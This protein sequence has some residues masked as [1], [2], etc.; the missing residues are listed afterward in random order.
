MKLH[1]KITIR[2]FRMACF[3][4]ILTLLFAEVSDVLVRKSLAEPWNMSVK[5]GGFYNEPKNSFDVMYFGSSHMYCSIDPQ[6]VEEQTGLHSYVLA[7]QEQP[8]WI[9][10]YYMKEALK[11]QSPKAIV[12]EVNM[13]MEDKK[14]PKE[15]T[16]YSAMDPIPLS[17]NKIDM[18]LASAPKGERR[19]YIFNIMKYHGR[20]EELNLEDYKRTYQKKCDPYQ[21]YVRL[22]QIVPIESRDDLSGV[23]EIGEPLPK[24][25]QYLEKIYEL[26]N[27]EGIILVFLKTPSNAT[28]EEQMF[29]N[30]AWKFAEE[31][32]IAYIDYNQKYEE[33]GLNL[34]E[35][36]CDRRHLNFR[37]AQKLTPNFSA[38]LLQQIS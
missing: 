2:I 21:G 4:L 7:T 10:Y 27:K 12:L 38:Y 20:W 6:T 30:A 25:M 24:T 35:D 23:T 13:M 18:V 22:E 17:K 31:H 37:G 15:G 33:L 16:L 26:A 28:R 19:N 11:T 36:F 9:S 29:Y 32:T 5:I 3:L 8:I 34:N 14:F 1:L